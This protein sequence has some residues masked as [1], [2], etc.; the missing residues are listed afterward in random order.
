M[1]QSS[2]NLCLGLLCCE[3]SVCRPQK[4]DFQDLEVLIS[5]L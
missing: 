5:A 4:Q 3:V 1:V 2:L